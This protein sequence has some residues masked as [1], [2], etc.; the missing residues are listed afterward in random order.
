[1]WLDIFKRAVD[2]SSRQRVADDLG[3]SRTAVSLVYSGKYPAST[4]KIA[5]LV[6]DTY[7]RVRCP[8]LDEEITHAECRRHHKAEAPTSSPRAMRH[9]K[10]CQSCPI[11][12]ANA[13]A[14]GEQHANS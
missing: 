9:W 1:M 10:A 6:M 13:S 14:K 4:D 8:H 5:T 3:I 2:A 12:V 7:G 11:K